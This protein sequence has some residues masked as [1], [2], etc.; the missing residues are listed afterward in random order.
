MRRLLMIASAAAITLAS[1][2]AGYAQSQ[3]GF[4]DRDQCQRGQQSCVL[5]PEGRGDR[6]GQGAG[7]G[8]SR[9]TPHSN[10]RAGDNGRNGQPFQRATNSRFKAPPR[11]QEYRVVNEHLVL[12]DSDT[13]KIVTVLGLLNTLLK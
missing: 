12:I 6:G 3:S 2:P 4:R 8:E 1:V 10:P 5:S 9:A 11:G 7:Q 13:L